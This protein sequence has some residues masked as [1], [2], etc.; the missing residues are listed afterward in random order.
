[1]QNDENEEKVVEE[2]QTEETQEEE[3]QEEEKDWK[4]EAKKWRAEAF[5]LK[6]TTNSDT[7]PNK[8][9][10]F[11]YDVKAYLKS[12]GINATE[13]DFVKQEMKEAGTKDVDSLLSN[14][15]FQSRLEEHRELTR[16]AEATPTGKRTGG[17]ATDSVDYWL[18]K[19]IEE[20]PQEKRR[21]VVKA[22]RE[23]EANKGKFYNS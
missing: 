3:T 20:V 2:E 9:N 19:P 11:G 12:S 10:D 6:G 1:M 21:E 22:K 8:S 7:A 18:S 4:A 15:Y 17:V 16:T 23:R 13:F 14:P 5:K